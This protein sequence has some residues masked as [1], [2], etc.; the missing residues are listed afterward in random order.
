M[1]PSPP[2]GHSFPN[3]VRPPAS[4]GYA[5][6]EVSAD[7]DVVLDAVSAVARPGA[8]AVFDLDGCL[9]DTRPRIVHLLRELAG[10]PGFL[11]LYAVEAKHLVDWDLGASMRRA[12][13]ANERAEALLP[14]AQAW[15]SRRFFTSECVL[16][17]HA[18]PGAP[19]L[20][21]SVF[22][23]GMS[24]V[25]L[26]GRHEEMR[27]G[28]ADALSRAGFPWARPGVRLVMKPDFRTDDTAFKG[29]ALREIEQL[30]PP[31]LFF[32]NEPSNVNLFA[33]RHP[34][35]LVVF[36]ETDHS[37]RPDRPQPSIPW[38]RG[39]MRRSDRPAAL[40]PAARGGA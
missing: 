38:V 13:I 37:P 5:P 22:T 4:R 27:A 23:T 17:D 18:M 16:H 28:T 32:D 12:G 6:F 1:N 35:A 20:V 9:F 24:V 33:D 31:V 26:T 36:V 11:D 3:P 29:E 39:F 14:E 21:W 34:Q 2:G 40:D 19:Q 8:V 15:F 25:Y 10:R 30:G 7:Q